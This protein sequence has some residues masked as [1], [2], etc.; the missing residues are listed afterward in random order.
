MIANITATVRKNV[1]VCMTT[2]FNE[3]P[4]IQITVGGQIYAQ[5]RYDPVESQEVILQKSQALAQATGLFSGEVMVEI[6]KG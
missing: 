6:P 4:V 5:M 3:I 2:T 1:G